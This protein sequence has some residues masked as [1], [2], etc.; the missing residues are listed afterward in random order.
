[1]VDRTIDFWAMVSSVDVAMT[2]A[3][4]ASWLS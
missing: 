1:M 3:A 4:T 2:E